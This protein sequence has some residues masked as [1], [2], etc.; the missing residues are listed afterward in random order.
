M[1]TTTSYGTWNNRVEP[2]AANFATSIY[3][4]LG[5]YADGFDLDAVEAEYKAAINDALPASV[6]L[7]GDE[8]IGPAYAADCDF[9]GYPTDED[10]RLDIKAI[11]DSIDFWEIASRHDTRA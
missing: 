9:T 11:V 10:G 1:T 5:D 3:E 7:C 8:F 6:N 2:Y 4:A